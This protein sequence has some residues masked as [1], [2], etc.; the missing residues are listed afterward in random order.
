MAEITPRRVG[1]VVGYGLLGL[2]GTVVSAM[3]LL[4]LLDPI[5]SPFYHGVYRQLG[6][7]GATQFAILSHFVVSGAIAALLPALA[8]EYLSD[9]GEN[10]RAFAVAVGAVALLVV[11]FLAIGAAGLESMPF[12]LAWVLAVAVG[13][14]AFL[15]FGLDV[16]SGGVPALVGTG[17]ALVL[18]LLLAGFGLGWGWGYVVVAEEVPDGSDE[19]VTFDDAPELREDLFAASGC[20]EDADGD[21][22]CELQL[23]GYEHERPAAAF[24]DRHGVRCPFGNAPSGPSGSLVAEHDGTHFE[25][26]C[27]AHGD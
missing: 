10:R 1:L 7:S 24:L 5:Q 20:E 12:G 23:R 17:P 15:Y 9:R 4:N 11:L 26:S 13:V 3:V 21:R 22:R 27:V 25:V 18:L 2:V 6:P 8:A 19:G 16:R 14:P